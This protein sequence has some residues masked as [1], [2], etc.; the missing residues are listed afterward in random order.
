MI[1]LL[2]LLLLLFILL[3]IIIYQF[4]FIVVY[5]KYLPVI[6]I[7]IIVQL[8]YTAIFALKGMLV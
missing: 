5:P 8:I 1:S 3:L 6:F 4:R 7:H 2:I